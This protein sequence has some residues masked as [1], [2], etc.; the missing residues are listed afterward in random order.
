MSV[1]GLA[2]PNLP[3]KFLPGV[4]WGVGRELGGGGRSAGSGVCGE[5]SGLGAARYARR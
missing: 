4:G 2:A 1:I 3:H 5:G